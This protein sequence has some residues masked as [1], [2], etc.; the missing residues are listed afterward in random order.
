MNE[1]FLDKNDNYK[2]FLLMS[3]FVISFFYD[4]EL[5]DPGDVII[6]KADLNSRNGKISEQICKC[7][8]HNN[9]RLVLI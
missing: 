3:G 4:K 8:S 7:V 9:S 2:F 1:I 5:F 6:L